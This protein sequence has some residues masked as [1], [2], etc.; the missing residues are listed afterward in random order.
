MQHLRNKSIGQSEYLIYLWETLLKPLNFGLGSPKNANHRGSH[1]SL[2][3]PEAYRI[4]KALIH[5]IDN[6]PKIIPDFREPDNIRLGIAPLYNTYEEIFFAVKR[7]EK[8]VGLKLYNSY[9]N[10]REVVT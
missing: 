5:P 8:I 7:M 10:K 2:R 1:I 6:S 9:S 3:H 4:C